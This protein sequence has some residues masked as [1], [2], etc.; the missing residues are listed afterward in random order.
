MLRNYRPWGKPG[1][2]APRVSYLPC[3]NNIPCLISCRQ[4]TIGIANA[5][6]YCIYSQAHRENS[7]APGQNIKKSPPASEPSR[8][9]SWSRN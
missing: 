4:T 3:L 1:G 5:K 9:F 8:K 6:R 7:E 2:G